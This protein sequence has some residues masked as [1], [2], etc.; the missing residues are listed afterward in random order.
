M[1]GNFKNQ[2]DMSHTKQ[3]FTIK[4]L[5]VGV[6]SVLVGFTFF[7]FN[8]QSASADVTSVTDPASDDRVTTPILSDKVAD[9]DATSRTAS[10]TEAGNTISASASASTSVQDV[11]TDTVTPINDPATSAV[12]NITSVIPNSTP[13]VTTDNTTSSKV[14]ATSTNTQYENNDKVIN[15]VSDEPYVGKNTET[16]TTSNHNTSIVNHSDSIESQAVGGEITNRTQEVFEQSINL[17]KNTTGN[18]GTTSSLTASINLTGQ[19]GDVFTLQIPKNATYGKPNVTNLNGAVGTTRVTEDNTYYYVKNSLFI[20]ASFQQE[21]VLSEYNNYQSQPKPIIGLGETELMMTLFGVNSTGESVGSTTKT[22]TAIIKPSMNPEFHRDNPSTSSA[23]EVAIKTNY[24]YLL[25]VNE[26]N[27]VKDSSSFSSSQINAAVNYGSTIT[28]PV[29]TSFTLDKTA[30]DNANGFL[31][32]TTITQ[33]GGIGTNIIISVPKGSGKQSYEGEHGYYLI[34]SYQMAEPNSDITLTANS[35]ISIIQKL[36]DDG[37]QILTSNAGTWTETIRGQDNTSSKGILT[38]SSSGASSS[39]TLLLDEDSSNN[40]TYINMFGFGNNSILNLSDIEITINIANGLSATGIVTPIDSKQLSGVT[41]YNYTLTYADNTSSY[42]TVKA[43]DTVMAASPSAIRTAVFKP[44]LVNVGDHTAIATYSNV[45]NRTDEFK[46]LGNIAKTYDDGSLVKDGDKVS[47]S[48]TATSKSLS[49]IKGGTILYPSWTSTSTQR[50]IGEEDLIA[51]Q[52]IY[53]Y[54]RDKTPGFDQAGYIAVRNIIDNRENTH[55]IKEPIYYY[56]IPK[57]VTYNVS[58]SKFIGSP[59]VSTFW[60]N[61]QQVVKIDYSGTGYYLDTTQTVNQVYLN[62]SNTAISGT[63]NISIYVTTATKMTNPSVSNISTFNSQFTEGNVNNTYLVGSSDWVITQAAALYTTGLAKGNTDDWYVNKGLSN[64]KGTT[65]MS[66]EIAVVNA[67]DMPAN[68]IRVYV[69]IPKTADSTHFKF[70]LSGPVTTDYT[71]IYTVLYST[72]PFL[73]TMPAEQIGSDY[74]MANQVIDWSTI[75]SIEIKIDK[76]DSSTS[77]GNFYL[78]GTDTTLANDA[79]K[80]ASLAFLVYADGYDRPQIVTAGSAGSPNITISGTST[81]KTVL[82][83]EDASGI[84]QTVNLHYSKSYTD[85]ISTVRKTDFPTVTTY[86]TQFDKHDLDIINNLLTQGYSI[87]NS[88]FPTNILEN[89]DTTWQDGSPN[90]LATFGNKSAYYFDGDKVVYKMRQMTA[91]ISSVP[92]AGITQLT[93][94]IT[95]KTTIYPI[96]TPIKSP[97]NNPDNYINHS[98]ATRTVKYMFEGNATIKPAVNDVLQTINF[99]SYNT[100]IVNL[101]TGEVLSTTTTDWI[102]VSGTTTATNTEIDDNGKISQTGAGNLNT[103]TSVVPA[104]SGVF[105]GWYLDSS[106]NSGTATLDANQNTTGQLVYKKYQVAN[107]AYV[108]TDSNDLL[109]SHDRVIGKQGNE[110]KFDYFNHLQG[111]LDQGYL[112]ASSDYQTTDTFDSDDNSDQLFMVKLSHRTTDSTEVKKFTRT[113]EVTNPDGSVTI[114]SQPAI[115]S[116]TVTTD[117]VT[118]NKTYSTWTTGEW[119]AYTTPTIIGYTPTIS[120]LINVRVTND[121]SDQ[122]VKI[123]YMPNQQQVRI[124]LIDQT[125]GITLSQDDLIGHS[126][127]AID[128]S[129]PNTQLNY[130]LNHGYQLTVNNPDITDLALTPTNYDHDDNVTQILNVFLIH[131]TTDSTESKTITRTI[132]V[133]NPDGTITSRIQ[134]VTL[135]RTVIT[136]QVTG[137]KTHGDWSISSWPEYIVASIDGYTPSV[138]TIKKQTVSIDTKDETIDVYYV[139]NSQPDIRQ[140]YAEFNEPVAQDQ[141]VKIGETPVASDS[142]ANKSELPEGTT[143]SYK[144]PVDTST[145]GTKDAT[146]VV[147]YP[148]GSTDEVPVKVIVEANPTQAETNEPIAQAQTVK[149]GQEPVAADSIANKSELP[150]GTTYSYKTPVDTSTPGTKDTTVVVTYPDGSI[151]EVPAKVI[152]EANP[153]QAETNEPIAQDQTVKIGQEPVASDSIANK[154]ELPEGTTYSYKTPVDTTTPGPKDTTVVVT[155]PDGSTDEVPAQ[156]TVL[157]YADS[158]EPVAQNQTVEVDA[159]PVTPESNE[160]ITQN[161]DLNVSELIN[162]NSNIPSDKMMQKSRLTDKKYPLVGTDHRADLPSTGVNEKHSSSTF[163]ILSISTFGALLAAKLRRKKD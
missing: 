84:T 34:G 151:D 90:N 74:V 50:V 88:N 134:P 160:L 54:Q 15:Q 48:I 91:K 109:L 105:T 77:A 111:Y 103:E 29:P 124:N 144:T 87:D 146:V 80:S 155:Y 89:G 67:F 106:S 95:G 86:T 107:L 113:I 23:S 71:G 18:D 101:V 157:P 133:Y 131:T 1:L 55:T 150:E 2:F 59:T 142:I 129:T 24:R 119:E 163:G 139:A 102:P 98:T 43:G 158:L 93:D 27:G 30:T 145:P 162:E 53:R 5:S 39:N 120:S 62:N 12:T 81:L 42:G 143:Y 125:T 94:L 61:N 35:P 13:K 51:A 115:I 126:D 31:D 16:T 32:Q 156:V 112:L 75:E 79:Q 149:V 21:I 104:V 136:D 41:S 82:E 57:G 44:N 70:D 10:D 132:N 137:E 123:S 37:S 147:T 117:N 47:S 19:A 99:E 52:N 122:T 69:N 8:G 148:D 63:Y 28:I 110:I 141:T 85:G 20:G 68:N 66:Y 11:S 6:V 65:A 108:D 14:E 83:Y 78:N 56:V 73:T 49:Y 3:R 7:G 127:Q 17:S 60:V 159:E 152:V 9:S 76:I 100:Y 116:R 161:Q 40:P 118:G 4:K 72:K 38:V 25:N 33:P 22:Y 45:D 135:T 130:Y 64:N 26:V 96:N 140:P 36:N 114:T 97:V 128:L 153:T 58:K 92:T 154:S 46:V 138:Q 121:L